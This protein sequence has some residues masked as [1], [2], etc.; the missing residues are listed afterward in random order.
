MVWWRSWSLLVLDELSTDIV[1]KKN[2]NEDQWKRRKQSEICEVKK[3]NA[4]TMVNPD[5]RVMIPCEI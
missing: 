4:T 3:E 2:W 5:P 1:E